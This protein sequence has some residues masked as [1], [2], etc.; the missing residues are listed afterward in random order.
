M[1]IY[2]NSSESEN[3]FKLFSLN[4]LLIQPMDYEDTFEPK[5]KRKTIENIGFW[6]IWQLIIRFGKYK[7]QKISPPLI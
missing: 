2:S 4:E 3:S 1:L 5:T 7:V 6:E